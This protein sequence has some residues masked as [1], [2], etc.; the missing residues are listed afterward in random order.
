MVTRNIGRSWIIATM[1][2]EKPCELSGILSDRIVRMIKL[3]Q[4][5]CNH[6]NSP[7]LYNLLANLVAQ[8]PGLSISPK[9]NASK[10]VE[11]KLARILASIH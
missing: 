5:Y 10:G 1:F 9:V 3:D 8:L 11:S 6:F 2:I 7:E 4:S